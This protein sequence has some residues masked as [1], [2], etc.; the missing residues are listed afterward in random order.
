MDIEKNGQCLC[1][2][3][4]FKVKIPEKHIH[5]CHCNICQNWGGGPSFAISA[6]SQN[7]TIS[8]EQYLKWYSS[9]EWAERGFCE[10]CGTHLFFRTKEGQGDYFGIS[11]GAVKDKDGYNIDSHIFIDKKPEFYDFSDDSPRLTEEEF[12]SQFAEGCDE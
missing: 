2:S 7:V 1:T 12:L 6:P 4:R 3:I 10:K 11:A 8:G 5:I 9:S